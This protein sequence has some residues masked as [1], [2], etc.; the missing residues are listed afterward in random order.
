MRFAGPLVALALTASVLAPSAPSAASSTP[1]MPSQ[2][3][4]VT[5]LP[6]YSNACEGAS[7]PPAG[8]A[9]AGLAA[10]C[11]RVYG[12]ALGKA[13]GSFG[14]NDSLLRSQVSS[15]M[16]RFIQLA[17][18]ELSATRTF[19][20]VNSGTVPD[21]QVR[22]E[23]ELLAGSGIIAGFPDGRF[24]P[25]DLLTVAQATT[26]VVRALALVHARFPA[27]PAFVDQ[28]TTSANYAAAGDNN[29][30]TTNVVDVHGSAYDLRPDGITERGLLAEVLVQGIQVL[31]DAAVVTSVGMGHKDGELGPGLTLDTVVL[32]GPNVV[33]VV[34]VDRAQGI[35]IRSTLAT[36]KLVG[37]LPTTSISRRW[38]AALAVNGDFFLSDG[39]PAHAFATGGRL[40]KAP[41]NV[42]DSNSFSSTNPRAAFFGTPAMTMEVSVAGTGASIPID[43]INDGDA[44]PGELAMYTPEGLGAATPPANSC[45][46]RL[47]PNGPPTINADGH[48][49]Q[50]HTV[51]TATCQAAAEP[52]GTDD[53]LVA[54]VNSTRAGFISSLTPDSTVT[55]SWTL[56]P[57]WPDL[58]DS[59]G[60][61]TTLVHNG[62]P[63]DDVVLGDGPYYD[64]VGPRSAVGQLADGRDVIAT[65]DGR[66][67]G[68][69]IGMT[70]LEFAQYL[71]S[72]GVV[73]AG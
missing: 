63:S 70:P 41:A 62:Q 1:T 29:L 26:I 45:F 44:A 71:V 40:L 52:V 14:E 19:A 65:V 23:I 18:V 20:D 32:D 38:R 56:N 10:D 55:T 58:L 21:A 69:S 49:E 42:E 24:R 39:Q 50:A 36:G 30:L 34:T 73:E 33:H 60:S 6:D 48:A 51:T 31:V 22:N 28:G 4:V 43:H 66:Q 47:T 37:R 53:L 27:A 3:A 2:A 11:L 13:D 61:N 15:L 5:T 59:T 17:G 35:E 68:Y 12:V 25:A 46:A 16:V 67:P 57:A 64:S 54:P 72:I 8:F 9:D 7:V